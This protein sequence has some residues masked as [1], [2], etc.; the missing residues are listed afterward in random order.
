MKQSTLLIGG[1]AVAGILWYR[2]QS[3]SAAPAPA[4]VGLDG[5][6]SFLFGGGRKPTLSTESAVRAETNGWLARIGSGLNVETLASFYGMHSTKYWPFIDAEL[7][8]HRI[9]PDYMQI[10]K[11]RAQ[12]RSRTASPK[13]TPVP[14][15]PG[16][17]PRVTL[18]PR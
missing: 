14:T 5:I 6:A 15:S 1:L 2:H 18:L 4:A 7:L 13:P 10:A 9:T 8:A 16:P 17:R 11:W 12:G 3:A